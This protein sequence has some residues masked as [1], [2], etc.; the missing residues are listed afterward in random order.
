M[1]NKK[2]KIENKVIAIWEYHSYEGCSRPSFYEKVDGTIFSDKEVEEMRQHIEDKFTKNNFPLIS[3]IVD[4]IKW[5]KECDISCIEVHGKYGD[6][7]V[8]TI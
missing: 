2:D 1:A 4:E 3:R 5:I 8:R 7:K 6:Y